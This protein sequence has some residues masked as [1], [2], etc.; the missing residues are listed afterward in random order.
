MRNACRYTKYTEYKKANS[1]TPKMMMAPLSFRMGRRCSS[2]INVRITRLVK[3]P[4]HAMG[5][6]LI[7]DHLLFKTVP[8]SNAPPWMQT[9]LALAILSQL[10]Y[11]LT[12]NASTKMNMLKVRVFN[13]MGQTQSLTNQPFVKIMTGLP[14]VT[15]S[16]PTGQQIRLLSS[17]LPDNQHHKV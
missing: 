3:K 10:R 17:P 12:P 7:S 6:L 15:N 2:M 16:Q 13:F 11:A 4:S 9:A 1:T 8:Q 5:I 14:T